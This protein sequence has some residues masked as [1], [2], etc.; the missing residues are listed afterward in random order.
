MTG[1]IENGHLRAD[2]ALG[3]TRR[4]AVEPKAYTDGP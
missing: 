1:G 2:I 3:E 4:G